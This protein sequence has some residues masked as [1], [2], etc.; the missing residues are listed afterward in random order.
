MPS[1][2]CHSL[3]LI[4]AMTNLQYLYDLFGVHV[5]QGNN[6]KY[7]YYYYYYDYSLSYTVPI[8]IF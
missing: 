3:L 4:N 2:L 1:P 8:S 6:Y 5:Y 7:Y